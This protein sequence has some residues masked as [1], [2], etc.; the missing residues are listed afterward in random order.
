MNTVLN[1]TLTFHFITNCYSC[2][3][4][5]FKLQNIIDTFLMVNHLMISF[6]MHGKGSYI[7]SWLFKMLSGCV[8]WSIWKVRIK[9]IFYSGIMCHHKIIEDVR[10]LIHTIYTAHKLS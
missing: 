6:C 1:S 2:L 3:G 7:S 10:D 5:F 8:F 4:L 9:V